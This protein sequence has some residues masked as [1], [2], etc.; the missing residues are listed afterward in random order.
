LTSSPPSGFAA[1]Q[2]TDSARQGL[3]PLKVD[4]AII[5][6]PA[7]KPIAHKLASGQRLTRSDGLA[8]MNTTDILGLGHLAHAARLAK[9]GLL[10][11]YVINRHLNYSNI[12]GVKCSFCAFWRDQDQE[13]SY[14]MDPGQKL[15]S[16]QGGSQKVDEVHIVGSCNPDLDFEYYEHL[17]R[18]TAETWPGATIKAFTAV[19]IAHI[20]DSNGM[21]VGQVLDR[22]QAAG[23][24]AMTGGGA[25]IFSPRVRELL[26][27]QKISG[28]RWLEVSG[29]AHNRGI[30]SNAT[31][32]YGHIET[33]AERVDHLL[34]L[35]DQQDKTGGFSAF[36]PLA[37]HPQNTQLQHIKQTSGL[38]DLKVVAASRLLLDNFP[39]IKAYWIMLGMKIAQVAQHFGADDLDGTIV[40]E[41]ITHT[42]GAK[43]AKG[44][45]ENEL[46]E[47]IKAAGFIP[48]RRDGFYNCL[49][50][51]ELQAAEEA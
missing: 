14:L 12:C 2:N 38:D 23:L 5:A 6:D 13:G 8:L 36:I 17:I 41:R 45:T 9:N 15:D 27:P 31:I 4:P 32:L 51:G 34:A 29:M 43:T 25:E 50:G 19:E 42:A 16:A 18:S 10:T 21:D 47:M 22:L 20:A 26:C 7:L 48:L 11:H 37:F 39:H 30:P 3:P 28:E 44:L 33:A 46:R 24:E 49:N 1:A 40:E 35:R